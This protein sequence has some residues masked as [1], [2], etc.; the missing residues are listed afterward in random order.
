M[1]SE[2]AVANDVGVGAGVSTGVAAA[3]AAQSRRG[4][5]DATRDVV[6]RLGVLG[7]GASAGLSPFVEGAGSTFVALA[8]SV[9]RTGFFCFPKNRTN[10][11]S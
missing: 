7:A 3:S 6:L 11:G 8:A 9:V 2:G 1:S 4:G 10:S 5:R